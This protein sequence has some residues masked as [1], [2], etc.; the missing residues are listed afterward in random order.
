M[1]WTWF[2]SRRGNFTFEKLSLRLNL[3]QEEEK[4]RF[5]IE[6]ILRRELEM[7]GQ[8]HLCRDGEMDD[9]GRLL[10]VRIAHPLLLLLL[11]LPQVYYL[12]Q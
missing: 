1:R 2:G 5:S 11:M 3:G 9:G 8:D 7:G 12:R 10:D 6:K 4:Q